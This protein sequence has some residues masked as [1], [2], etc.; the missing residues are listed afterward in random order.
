[1]IHHYFMVSNYS[2]HFP[3]MSCTDRTTFQFII[4]DYYTAIATTL[5]KK[6]DAVNEMKKDTVNDMKED[7]VNDMKEDIVDEDCG[8]LTQFGLI[9]MFWKISIFWAY[10]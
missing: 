1:M 10:F 6:E 3:F 2:A 5:L 4:D 9:W 7:T 8:L